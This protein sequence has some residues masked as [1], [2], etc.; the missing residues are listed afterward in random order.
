M[1]WFRISI[2]FVLFCLIF[3]F[4]SP[5]TALKKLFECNTR[6]TFYAVILVPFFL[7]FRLCK[8]F[9]LARQADT[10]IR[11][12]EIIPHYL[13]GMAVGL[14]T[15]GRLGELARL[16]GLNITKKQGASLFFLEKFI[17]FG[18]IA[19]LCMT[20]AILLGLISFWYF[21]VTV[22]GAFVFY[23]LALKFIGFP[24]YI[25]EIK[26]EI[27]KVKITG[28]LFCTFLC[29]FIF[30]V[31]AFIIL[32]SMHVNIDADVIFFFPIILTGNFIPITV[33][34]FG[35]RETIAIVIL[36]Q[37]DIPSEIAMASITL[38]ALIDLVL[39]ALMG[40]IMNLYHKPTNSPQ[41]TTTNSGKSGKGNASPD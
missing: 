33:G 35:I 13:W 16:R 25:K 24:A 9:L 17:E 22:A 4:V 28:C 30:C 14:I 20:A 23:F 40:L 6:L 34:G 39:P 38:V 41:G 7:F 11:L 19:F 8:W 37:R 1:I 3:I 5:I 21:P 26:H 27:T 36:R 18:V 10:R 32:R 31:Q 29:V 12:M 2:T 15:P